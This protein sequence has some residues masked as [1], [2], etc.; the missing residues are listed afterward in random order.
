MATVTRWSNVAVAI[1]SSLATAVTINSISKAA[2]AAVA[3]TGT[4]PTTGDYLKLAVQ[5]MYELDGRVVRAANVVGGSNTLDLEGIDSQAFNTFSSGTFEVITFGTTLSTLTGLNASGGDFDFID[6]STI[7]SAVKTQIPGSASPATYTFESIWD[8]ADAGLI[9]LK[10]ASDT[11]ALR[12]VRFTFGTGAKVVFSG[13]IGATLLPTG[14]AGDK[15]VTSVTITM[16]GRPTTY[17][18]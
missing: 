13:Y 4:D 10:N 7:H 17:S 9:A 14:S 11:Q 2:T 1:Q 15:V 16:F 3:Y 8:P 12:A 18:S 5:G 6:T